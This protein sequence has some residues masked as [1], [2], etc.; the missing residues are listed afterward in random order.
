MSLVS[1]YILKLFIEQ[2]SLAI[3]PFE[4]ARVLII[5]IRIEVRYAVA[6]KGRKDVE[7]FF[8]NL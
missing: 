5:Q 1:I 4:I 8:Y 6:D 2:S 3:R 7:R